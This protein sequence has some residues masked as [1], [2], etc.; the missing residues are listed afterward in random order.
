[1][2]KFLSLMLAVVL[3]SSVS[4]SQ[5]YASKQ[6][7]KNG[8]LSV[9]KKVTKTNTNRA[10]NAVFFSDDFES[11]DL[12]GWTTADEDGDGNNWAATPGQGVGGSTT[13]QSESWNGAAYTP[14]NWLISGAIDLSTAGAS[15]LLDFWRKAQDQTW[16]AEKYTVYLSTSGN[17][18]ADFTGA[19]GHIILP[20]ET[21]MADD[22][23]KRSISLASYTGGTVYI[24]FRHHDCTDM[25]RLNID[26]VEIYENATVDGGITAFVA[27]NNDG[28]CSLTATEDVTVT[29]FNYG[30]AALTG[31]DVSYTINGGAAVTETVTASIPP[32]S[33]IDYTFTQTADLS[34]LGYY[35]FDVTLT[36][37]SD[38]NADN[39]TWS[40]QHIANGDD[41]MT[42]DVSTDSQ[43][44][45]AWYVTNMVTGDTIAQHGQYQWNLV[46]DI[47]TVCLNNADCYNFSWVG[48][49]SNDVVVTHGGSVI[50][51]RTATGDYQLYG[52]GSGC[53]ADDFDLTSVNTPMTV[54]LGNIDITGTVTNTGT[55]NLT[56]FDVVYTIDGG[57]ASAIYTAT[58][59]VATGETFDFTHNVAWNAIL[60]DHTIEVTVDNANGNGNGGGVL[61]ADIT[62]I[63]EIFPKT[64]VY[65]EGTGTW[66]GWCVRGL[67][68]LST[69]HHNITD[70]SW[71]GIAVHNGDPMVLAEYDNAIGPY[72]P[73][74]Y[75][76]GIMNRYPIEVDPGLAS[77]EAY[78][79]A[80]MDVVPVAKIEVSD[81]TWNS[82]SR[83][84]TVE[85]TTTFGVDMASADYNA[86]LIVVEDGVTG[87]GAGWE[88]ANYYSGG[89][90]GDMIDWDGTNYANSAD[91]IPA[92]DMV[93][94]HVGRQL[95]GGWSGV[96]GS[97]PASVTYNVGNT[98]T[99]S[100]NIPADNNENET[101]YV[102]I[103]IDNSNG[104]IVNATSIDLDITSGIVSKEASFNVYPNPTTGL[105][106]V[107]G[108]EGAQVEVYNMIGEVVY[109]EAN[110]AA[111][112]TID[113]STLESGNY[114][115]K[116]INNDEVSTQKIVLTK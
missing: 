81:Q 69:M 50:D 49:T 43:G 70:G 27:P 83:D 106:Q 68:G 15:T 4:F 52:I 95:I 30:G 39:D 23:Q 101:H 108:I 35:N 46:N 80:H 74:G 104:T 64:V 62:V 40:V 58:C 20:Q 63:N 18:V 22:W 115:I 71:I 14:D 65:E 116:V 25:F 82:T 13:A 28:G 86:A 11:G 37:A 112:T 59:D 57:A 10:V 84:F 79:D 61:S 32:A 47:T 48:G 53:A 114:I 88:Q 66:C 85:V 44:D 102:A 107:E 76:G 75:P 111:S 90:S 73:S 89:M 96:D 72:I 109:N 12:S 98:Y 7:A 38:A 17:T 77:L 16:P 34:S 110:T 41:Q 36:I 42:I 67:V 91:P 93:Y 1:M 29:I 55:A 113:L 31:F 3:L 97:I 94:N 8:K 45:Q 92:A 9:A 6:D 26:D 56:S 54:D 99:F 19:N 78:Y 105:V 21:V 24:A 87:T 2:R 33:S 100:G 5:T 51:S 60:G 103:I